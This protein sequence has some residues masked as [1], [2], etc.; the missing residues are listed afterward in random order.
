M[1]TIIADNIISP[2]GY[3]TKDNYRAVKSGK[4][5]L[6][7]YSNM[8]GVPFSFT[9]SL[10][11]EEQRAKLQIQ[12]YTFF[13]SLAINSIRSALE[14]VN[15]D[16]HKTILIISS[17]KANVDLLT[18][19]HTDENI[20]S[21]A[22]AA[23]RIANAIG[24]KNCPVVVSNA[25]ISGVSAVLLAQRLIAINSYDNCIVC[26]VDHQSPFIISGF[27]S[28]KA[29]SEDY[30]RP[31]DIERLGLN[32]GE[33][34]ATIIVSKE[35]PLKNNKWEI[36]SGAIRNDAY[37]ISSPS[38]Q[39][40]G[41]MNAISYT[42]QDIN[43]EVLALLNAHGTATMYNDQMESKAI[44]NAGLSD[45]PV[46]ALKGYYG[47]TM[48]AAG[49]LETI[50]TMCSIDDNII[51]GTKGF[52]ELGVSGRICLTTENLQ[53]NKRDFVKIISGFGGCNGAIHLSKTGAY[54][55]VNVDRIKTDITHSIQINQDGVTIDG[56]PLLVNVRGKELLTYLYKT[57]IGNYPRFYKMDGLAKLGFMAAEL[58]HQKENLED[59]PSNNRAIVFFNKYSSLNAD[60]TY[61]KSI[62][63]ME[64]Y[65]PSPSEFVYTL[66]NIVCGEIAIRQNYKGETCFYILPEEDEDRIQSIIQSTFYDRKTKSVICGWLEYEN[67]N[68]FYA[69]INI[70]TNNGRTYFTN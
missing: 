31:F 29:L 38:P 61:M 15:I 35:E 67:D 8:E 32:L 70:I 5:A 13:E 44:S 4:T 28:L 39:G 7:H 16:L 25:C 37:H 36:V 34:A 55:N 22:V 14:Q 1:A 43:Q 24:I 47:H 12:G 27:Q 64:N 51:L 30:C 50:L 66:P 59:F 21:P 2:L 19:N 53:T 42:L 6:C 10:F 17:T 57:H 58:L 46:N 45:I 60:M 48:G 26:G 18:R 33:A 49:V 11:S 3:T 62:T 40:E 65:F 54:A 69:S 52:E 68:K 41:C 56:S 20:L 63:D 23:Q 9:A